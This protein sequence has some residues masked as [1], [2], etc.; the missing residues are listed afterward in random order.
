M[1]EVAKEVNEMEQDVENYN[2]CF[3]EC[4]LSFSSWR[5]FAKRVDKLNQMV[6]KLKD[7]NF[8]MNYIAV[9]SLPPTTLIFPHN[10]SEG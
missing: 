8:Y 2:K 6:N 7:K 4:S 1:E 3:A 9:D 5:K 10:Y